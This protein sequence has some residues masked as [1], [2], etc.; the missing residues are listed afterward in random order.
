[1]NKNTILKHLG[2][3][4]QYAGVIL[5]KDGQPDHH[6][7]LMPGEVSGVDWQGALT[8]AQNLGG[9]LPTRRE[10]ALLYAN[11]PEEFQLDWYWS[12]TQYAPYPY[13]AWFQLFDYGYQYHTRKGAEG[14]ARAVRRIV[15]EE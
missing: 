1:M 6:L 3:G 7:V 8:W 4:E 14:R 5:G 13:A 11:L 10:Q 12:S 15:I 9:D 2:P